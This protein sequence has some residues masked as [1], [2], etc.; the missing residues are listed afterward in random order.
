M[1]L[2]GRERIFGFSFE[3]N[4]III[5]LFTFVLLMF[6]VTADEESCDRRLHSKMGSR[7]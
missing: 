4:I 2:A 7:A 1:K 3:N 5:I 6:I